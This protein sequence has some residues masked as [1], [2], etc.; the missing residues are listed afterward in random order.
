MD[1]DQRRRNYDHPHVRRNDSSDGE[2]EVDAIDTWHILAGEH[3]LSDFGAL[4][5]GQPHAVIHP[6]LILPG[7][8]VL[9]LLSLTLLTLALLILLTHP[10]LLILLLALLSLSLAL[11]L[12]LALSLGWALALLALLGLTLL[13]LGRR[14]LILLALHALIPLGGTLLALFSLVRS[15]ARRFIPLSLALAA[16][17]LVPLS[18]LLRFVLR[19]AALPLFPL[20]RLAAAILAC[21]AAFGRSTRLT[22]LTTA[23]HVLGRGQCDSRHQRCRTE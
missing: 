10:G 15:L 21:G 13:A 18:L 22:G 17:G 3:R 16:L 23:R 8:V 6:A 12:L 19:L 4:L 9:T 14:G 5:R 2:R 20:L 1:L 7:L 11:V